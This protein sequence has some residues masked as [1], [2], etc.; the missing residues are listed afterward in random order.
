VSFI[1][2]AAPASGAALT[3]AG[4]S[5]TTDGRGEITLAE[6]APWDSLLDVDGPNILDR[7]TLV[8]SSTG[9]ALTVWPRT[10]SV[11]ID[12]HYISMLVY[13]SAGIAGG[14]DGAWPLHRLRPGTAEVVVVPD[15]ALQ[16][17]SRSLGAHEE[18]A[19]R[20]TLASGGRVTY[21]VA[22]A[23][24]ATGVV[25]ETKLAPEN[26]TCRSP[27]PTVSAFA[28][29]SANA[30]G[31]IFGSTIVYCDE[32]GIVDYPNL[33][34]HEL[35]HTFGLQHSPEPH[36]VMRAPAYSSGYMSARESQAMLQ[37]LARPAGNRY[38]DNDRGARVASPSSTVIRC[39]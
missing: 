29:N 20:M 22:A 18:A 2:D 24:P 30:A 36:E 9:S 39:Y 23:R 26:S 10:T 13:T 27:G 19:A 38:P 16:A 6:N 1:H 17:N 12:P 11:G 4:R 35:G 14:D 8:R 15:P 21:R 3:I 5:Y 25:V 32:K 28:Q 33:I 31:E 37:L 34:L 7:Q